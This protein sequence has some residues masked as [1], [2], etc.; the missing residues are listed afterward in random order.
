M[1]SGLVLWLVVVM[2]SACGSRATEQ[3]AV[4]SKELLISCCLSPECPT[5]QSELLVPPIL[6]PGGFSWQCLLSDSRCSSS[7]S[8]P[9]PCPCGIQM[10]VCGT[11]GGQKALDRVHSQK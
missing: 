8:Y 9:S 5:L 6:D 1:G 7:L 11:R 10:K 2:L 4:F 3:P